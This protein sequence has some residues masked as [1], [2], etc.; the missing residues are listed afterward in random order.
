MFGARVA[1]ALRFGIVLAKHGGALPQMV[2]PF[3]FGIGG[4]IGSGAQWMSWIALEDVVRIIGFALST[5]LLSGPANAVAPHPVRNGEFATDLGLVLHRPSLLPMPAF[6]LRLMFGEMADSLLLS[7]QRVTPRKLE[8]LG[9]RFAHSELQSAPSTP[10]C[11]V[12]ADCLH[13]ISQAARKSSHIQ[14]FPRLR[15]LSPFDTNVRF[16]RSPF[17]P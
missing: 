8:H 17:Q 16:A 11:A 4:P 2:L 6:A 15:Q 7:S 3:R 13:A 14:H 10:S 9:Y 1:L 12:R 5:N